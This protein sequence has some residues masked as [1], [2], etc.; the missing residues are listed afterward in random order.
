MDHAVK[1][2]NSSKRSLTAP[3]LLRRGFTLVE[4]LVVIGIIAMLIAILLPALQ[5]ARRQANAVSCLANMR[6]QGMGIAMYYHEWRAWPI[7]SDHVIPVQTGQ[8][9]W[10]DQISPYVKTLGCEMENLPQSPLPGTITNYWY[11]GRSYKNLWAVP[12]DQIARTIFKCPSDDPQE[13]SGSGISYAWNWNLS[14]DQ[15]GKYYRYTAANVKQSGNT[16]MTV[17]GGGNSSGGRRMFFYNAAP[18]AGGRG[19]RNDS[20][21]A[22]HASAKDRMKFNYGLLLP[23]PTPVTRKSGF[24]APVM[25]YLS[26]D[27]RPDWM[28]TQRHPN[29]RARH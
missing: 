27:M 15:G 21:G 8:W 9:Q 12:K 17:C 11:L 28:L 22:Y 2:M 7:R 23:P 20:A 25:R 13:P 24:R 1:R 16:V 6:Q 4:L 3:H 10:S 19:S 14:V 5:S 18:G 26:M 29:T